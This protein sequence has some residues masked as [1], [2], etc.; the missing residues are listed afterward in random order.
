MGLNPQYQASN[1]VS[2]SSN[3]FN[4]AEILPTRRRCELRD[5]WRWGRLFSAPSINLFNFRPLACVAGS[6]RMPASSGHTAAL[7]TLRGRSNKKNL[8]PLG[9]NINLSFTNDIHN[10]PSPWDQKNGE[11]GK[12]ESKM[13]RRGGECGRA[14]P[15]G[16]EQ[17]RGGAKIVGKRWLLKFIAKKYIGYKFVS[18]K[19]WSNKSDGDLFAAFTISTPAIIPTAVE[20][21]T[22]NSWYTFWAAASTTTALWCGSSTRD[23]P[24][25]VGLICMHKKNL[26]LKNIPCNIINK[27]SSQRCNIRE[28]SMFCL[29]NCWHWHYLWLI[30]FYDLAETVAKCCSKIEQNLVAKWKIRRGSNPCFFLRP[31]GCG[32]TIPPPRGRGVTDPPP[33]GRGGGIFYYRTLHSDPAP[34]WPDRP[35]RVGE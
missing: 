7:P 5:T 27:A 2:K 8:H 3:R 26:H 1:E 14:G 29:Y 4:V 15:G 22:G 18:V 17:S 21:I 13:M 20:V 16:R 19:A 11:G 33:P 31:R 28:I 9:V 6:Q 30:F 24:S 34:F 25:E 12:R 32:R 35:I 23:T 10:G